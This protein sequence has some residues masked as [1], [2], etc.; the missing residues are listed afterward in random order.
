MTGLSTNLNLLYPHLFKIASF[1]DDF[2]PPHVE[3]IFRGSVVWVVGG[4]VKNSVGL[5]YL[6]NNLGCSDNFSDIMLP[7][8]INILLQISLKGSK[9]KS[10]TISLYM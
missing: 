10:V 8:V 7:Y 9:Q 3:D 1:V 6:H 2:Y 5:K 4:D